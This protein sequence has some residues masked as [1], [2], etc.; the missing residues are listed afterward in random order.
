[1]PSECPWIVEITTET[2]QQEVVDRSQ[3]TP[4]VVDFWAEWCGPCRQLAPLLEQLAEENSGRFILAKVNVDQEPA[5][6]QAFGV[7]SIP[8]VVAVVDGQPA[9]PF[10]GVLPEP[11]LRKWLENI[12][13]SKSQELIRQGEELEESDPVTAEAKYREALELE[14][15]LDAARIRLARVLLAQHRLADAR[16]LIASLE[17]RGFLEPEAEKVKS[18]LELVEAAADSG[19]VEEARKAATAAPDDLAAQLALADALAVGRQFE[20]AFEI[21]LTII[22][23]DRTGVGAEAKEAMVKMFDLAGPGELVSRYRRRLSTL[24]Y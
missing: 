14:P 5:I 15:T 1:M 22:E 7:Q 6:A 16:E 2:F 23:R 24:L 12:L 9:H 11:E 20:E 4:I 17:E 3:Q 18:E 10:Q 8:F 19:G 21:C 13:P